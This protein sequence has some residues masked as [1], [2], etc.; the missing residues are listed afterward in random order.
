MVD[1]YRGA[2][3]DGRRA[4]WASFGGWTLEAADAQVFGLVLP[5]LLAVWRLSNGEGGLLASATLVCTGV[6]GWLAGV[7][8]D[9]WG[10]VR[11]LQVTIAWYAAA[12]ALL[13]FADGFGSLLALRCLQ[14]FGFGGEWAAGAVLISE[15][16]GT[17]HRGRVL[18][19]VQSGWAVGW[20][21]AL[22][23]YAVVTGFAP[24]TWAWRIMFWLGVLPAL[25]VLGL[26]RGLG[27]PRGDDPR[28]RTASIGRIFQPGLVRVT[29]VG[30]LLGLGAHGGYYALT[31]FLPTYL[32]RVRGLTTLGTGG[33]L[34]VFVAASFLGYLASG[35][36]ADRIGRRTNIVCFAV[37]C[38][39]AVAGFLLVPL[40]NTAM[41]LAGAPLGFAAA[42]IPGGLGAWYAELFPT[43]VRGS[44][45]GFC[46]NAGRV[47]SAVFPA[48][49]GLLSTRL[50]L[51]PSIAVF[52][53][54]A[55]ALVVVAAL[56]LP[57]TRRSGLP[58]LADHRATMVPTPG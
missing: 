50:G 5:M 40:D 7:A 44:G 38:V 14:G 27:D 19:A 52:A 51:G 13:G 8:S 49:V 55:Y 46:Y 10:R 3:P 33:Y 28:R 57:E 34:A 12:T 23:A 24:D 31:T 29:L 26:R 42:G 58:E 39:L 48:L 18:G 32:R 2:P 21:G 20:A 22:G 1:W 43:P 25:L 56:L 53:G 37:L 54:S 17:R 47:V 9:R 16:V 36:L 35:W 45:Q 41:L 4:F 30:A 11:V 6:G 15:F